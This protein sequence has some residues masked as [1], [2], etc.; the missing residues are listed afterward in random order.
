M[1]PLIKQPDRKLKILYQSVDLAADDRHDPQAVS[2]KGSGADR[3]IFSGHGRLFD[4][5]EL[6]ALN[7]KISPTLS[8]EHGFSAYRSTAMMFA[9][10]FPYQD[11]F[12]E[13]ISKVSLSV[14]L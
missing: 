9:L 7:R 10:N 5:D 13:V 12:L 3:L 4:G 6:N 1:S 8:L 14:Y 2:G 11:Q